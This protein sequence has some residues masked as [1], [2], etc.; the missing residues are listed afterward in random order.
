MYD[1]LF[2]TKGE[3]MKKILKTTMATTLSIG[4]AFSISGCSNET[5]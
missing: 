1:L 4:F 5:M 3:M 2:I